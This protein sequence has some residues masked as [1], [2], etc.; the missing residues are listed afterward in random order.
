MDA[1]R[2]NPFNQAVTL[3]FTLPLAQPVLL[4][5]YNTTGREVARLVDGELDRGTHNLVWNADHISEGVYIA[6]LST[7][8]GVRVV[9]MVMVK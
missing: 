1:P 5:V 8:L 6:R 2:P 7:P 3:R 9:K 4:A